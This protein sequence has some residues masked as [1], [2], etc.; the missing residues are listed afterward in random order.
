MGQ[1]LSGGGKARPPQLSQAHTH[2][3]SCCARISR[4]SLAP[5]VLET[6][7]SDP[8]PGAGHPTHTP[9]VLGPRQTHWSWALGIWRANG[10]QRDFIAS[11]PNRDL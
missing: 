2:T 9:T 4:A 10:P 3:H 7:P 11:L 1:R 8:E 6:P 5:R